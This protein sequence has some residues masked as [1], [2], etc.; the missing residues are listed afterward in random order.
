MGLP[1]IISY[2]SLT[3][4]LNTP[5][6]G[7]T[8]TLEQTR[9]SRTTRGGDQII[10]HD[11]IWPTTEKLV[12]KFEDLTQQ[13]ASQYLDFMN[14]TLGNNVTLVDHNGRTWVGL[15]VNPEATIEQ[16]G[17]DDVNCGRGF[18]LE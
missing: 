14:I 4:V 9:I 3:V 12:L 15:L 5:V 1:V 2:G 10:F 8:D 11:P 18:N 17:R 6:F 16:V 7:N 13:Q